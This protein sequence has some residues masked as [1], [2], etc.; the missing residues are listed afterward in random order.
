[1]SSIEGARVARENLQRGQS[2]AE[3]SMSQIERNFSTSFDLVRNLNLKMVEMM[4]AHTDAAFD[5]AQELVTAK[6]PPEA[7]EAC[8]SFAERQVD[9]VQKQTGQLAAM[10]QT[11]ANDTVQSAKDTADRFAQSA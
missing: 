1:M 7:F 3:E 5:L 2:V 11:A 9:A 4:R 10:T 6:S 8:R